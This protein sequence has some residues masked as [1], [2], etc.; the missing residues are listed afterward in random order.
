MSGRGIGLVVGVGVLAAANWSA[1]IAAENI[2]ETVETIGEPHPRH[3]AAFIEFEDKFYLLGGRRVQPVSIYD[4]KTNA[5]SEGT[6][7]PVEIHHFQPVPLGDR[8][9]L[10]GAM[11]GPYPNEVGLDRV[12]TYLPKEDR[13]EF[14]H[15]IPEDRRRGGAGAVARNG[16]IYMSCGI[17]NG[18]IGGF[19]NWFDEYDPKTGAWKE[20]PNAPHKRDHFQSAI[21]DG[22]MY[23]ARGRTTSKETNQVFD[24]T[25]PQVDVYDFRTGKWAVLK[26]PLPTPRAGNSTMRLNEEIL[27]VGGESIR[28]KT[29][30]S[31]VEAWDAASERWKIYPSLVQGR[32]GSG[33]F[34]W[35]KYLYTCSGS[36]NRGGRPELTSMERLK[37]R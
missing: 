11:T 2:W 3:E 14:T 32:H 13:W 20:L 6:P 35:E 25:V 15:D 21:L 28:Q 31:E 30:H 1:A 24:L 34:L 16:K 29:A 10:L 12:L 26:D 36:G 17:I 27:V 7:P 4:P 23:C 22:K 18:H 19:V 33:V 8:I 9:H 5:W 37:V